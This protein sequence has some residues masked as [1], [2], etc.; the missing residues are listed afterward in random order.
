[1]SDHEMRLQIY[2]FF[3]GQI[4][5]LFTALQKSA[6]RLLPREDSPSLYTYLV[7]YLHI[8]VLSS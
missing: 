5:S 7:N 1:M 2:I 4:R 3:P 8:I 6:W